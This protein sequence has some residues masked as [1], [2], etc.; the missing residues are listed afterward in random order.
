[1]KPTAIRLAAALLLGFV[2]ASPAT[3]T[4]AASAG[5][6]MER[7]QRAFHYAGADAKGRLTMELI[8]R[9]GG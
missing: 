6:I 3:E 5:E 4:L 7:S 8:A 2:L 9:D 1:M